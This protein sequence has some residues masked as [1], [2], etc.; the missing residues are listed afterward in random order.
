MNEE[1]FW[2]V[3]NP[4]RNPPNYRH[5]YERGAL[6]EAERLA[7]L[8]P[9]QSFYVLQATHLCTLPKPVICTQLVEP[10]PF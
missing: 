3:W 9:G 7:A 4:E 10:I 6:S 8:H 5:D 1:K 2:M